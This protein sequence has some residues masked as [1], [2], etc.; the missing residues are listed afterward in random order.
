[1]FPID[2]DILRTKITTS[3]STR[4]KS[5][6]PVEVSQRDGSKCVW[7]GASA[8]YCEAVH[9]LAHS[10]ANE[11]ISTLTRRRGRDNEAD[12]IEDI[13]SANVDDTA[14]P[15]QK[16]YTAHI[17]QNGDT[18]PSD[19]VLGS[20]FR[21]AENVHAQF[22]PD[23]LF[24]AVYASFMVHQFGTEAMKDSARKWEDTFYSKGPMTQREAAHRA[25]L[26]ECASAKEK[27]KKQALD[28]DECRENR[29][30]LKSGQARDLIDM[31]LAIPYILV[32]PDE[33]LEMMRQAREELEAVEQRCVQKKVEEW[34]RHVDAA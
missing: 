17:M 6:F 30:R 33:H 18:V 22:P 25:I 14:P 28:R 19:C 12:V 27:T 7:T 20:S 24:D 32:L 2:P 29:K 1:M 15:E 13:D 16:R 3:V 23:I 10:K 9:L 4:R 34:M 31:L 26:D 21:I 8:K 5:T 11:Y